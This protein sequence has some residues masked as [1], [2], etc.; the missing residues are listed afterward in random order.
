MLP[1]ITGEC[2]NYTERWYYNAYD[3]RCTQFYYGGCGGNE[4]NFLTQQDCEQRCE[5][6]E[7]QAPEEEFRREYCFLPYDVGPCSDR[8]AQSYYDSQDGVCKQFLYGGCYGNQNRFS[9]V[10]EC[11]RKCGNSQDV[12]QLPKVVGP[13]DGDYQ[14]WFF[15][16]T[17]GECLEF[18]YGGCQGNGNRFESKRLCEEYCLRYQ[19]PPEPPQRPD[20]DFILSTQSPSANEVAPSDICSAPVDAGPCREA[21]TNWYFNEVSGQCEAF[22]YGGC[23]GNANRFESEEQCER[24]CGSFKGQDVCNIPHDVGPCRGAIQKWYFDPHVRRC[25][26]FDYGGCYGNGNRFSSVEECESVC[27]R[28]EE[29]LPS[30]N[31]TEQTNVAICRQPVDSGPCPTGHYKRWYFDED[32]KTCI[33]FIYTGCGGNLNR[34]KNF[35]YCL[36]FCSVLLYESTR[37][38][39]VYDVPSHCRISAERCKELHCAYGISKSVDRDNCEVCY[40]YDPC[41][42]VVCPE[43]SSCSADIYIESS[44]GET[45]FRPACRNVNKEG[46]CPQQVLV[47]GNCSDECNT[48]ADCADDLKC[49]FNGCGS[50]CI[51]PAASDSERPER[52]Y[53]EGEPPYIQESDSIVRAPEGN[54]ATLKCDAFG[55]PSPVVTWKKGSTAIETSGSRHQ[56]LD[57]GSLKIINLYR[58]DAGRYVCTADNG[59]GSP[60]TRETELEVTDPTNQPAE[61]LGEEHEVVVTT[62]GTPQTLYCRAVGWPRPLITWWRGDRML[63]LSSQVYEQGRDF[64]LLIRSVTLRN[65]GLFTCQAYN[66]L[67]RA[68]SWTVTVKALGPVYTIDPADS[69]YTKYLISPSL[70]PRTPPPYRPIYPPVQ[71]EPQTEPPPPRAFQVPVEANITLTRSIYPVGSDISI[72]CAVAGFPVPRVNWYKDENLLEEN[73]KIQISESHRLFISQA[74]KSD[75][76]TY[77]CEAINE[78]GSSYSTISIIIEGVYIHPNCTDNPFFANCKLIVAAKY[79]THKYYARFCCKSCTQAGQLPSI[80]PHLE[81]AGLQSRLSSFR[82]KE[83]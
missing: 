69:I 64:S 19:P 2:H 6:K 23:Q 12:C 83:N 80:G 21:V 48:D 44:S 42:G 74:D 54:Y 49:C 8:R 9:T 51:R 46:V 1:A 72:P 11:E 50:S 5:R 4:N 67:G 7:V 82:R 10:H 47:S 35:Q 66:G 37:S 18:A 20:I 13:C 79:C 70:S 31:D 45:A 57:D 27:Y 34:F 63:P 29:R 68:A 24:Q 3:V 41:E 58:Q 43:G 81:P 52:P 32:R 36:N 53:P 28:R 65:L 22:I 78:F 59:V 15:D 75:A 62:L 55:N 39:D 56:I 71:P 14:Q 61:I 26:T 76:G 38:K 17:R 30:G 16:Q 33:P 25:Q 73:S 40:C 77:R 60:A